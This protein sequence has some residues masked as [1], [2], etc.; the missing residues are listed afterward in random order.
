MAELRGSDLAGCVLD[1]VHDLATSAR[2]P[3][4]EKPKPRVSRTIRHEREIAGPGGLPDPWPVIVWTASH[5]SLKA[6]AAEIDVPRSRHPGD[7]EAQPGIDDD[8]VLV[9]SGVARDDAAD[10]RLG[11]AEPLQH[12]HLD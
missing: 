1:P 6:V 11:I 10:S 2:K 12:R 5:V 3:C 7:L 8:H 9:G 4:E